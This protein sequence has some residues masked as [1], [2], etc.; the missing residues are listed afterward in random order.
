MN[1]RTL[2]TRNEK[3]ITI[4]KKYI[5]LL[6]IALIAVLSFAGCGKKSEKITIAIPNDT[7]N[8]ARA[9]LLLEDLGYIK[10]KDGA[11]ITATIRDIEENS[12]NIEFEEVE[13]A[14]LPNVLKD[15]D[16]A[17]INS[18]YAIEA[19]LNPAKDAL[20]IEG[21]SSAYG[22]ILA[23]KEGNENSDLIKAL[24]AA[25]ESK[26]VADFIASE[27]DGA[28]V[29]VVDNLTDGYDASVDYT[30]LEGKTVSVAA[31]PTPHAEILAIVKDILAE[32]K[33]TLDIKEFTD[34][35]Q[36]NNVVESGDI[37]AN[38]FQH[39]PYL[40]DFNKENNTHIVSVAAIHVEPLGIY[41][42]K[43][44]TLDAIKK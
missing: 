1:N 30:A 23:V 14:Q 28:V 26:Q 13:A 31:S 25:L 34:Y 4:M 24:V 43:Q 42:G 18:N 11:G 9:L 6:L 22:N 41:G 38:Y 44:T 15:V 17:V 20:G 35:V 8:E 2:K 16:Y 27:Y 29:S 39:V 10:L 32:K 21:S 37:D 40:D 36:P 3:E 33:I 12:Y 7:T 5:S 19:K